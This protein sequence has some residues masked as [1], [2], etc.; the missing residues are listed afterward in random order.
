LT[1]RSA[2]KHVVSLGAE[3]R[4]DLERAARSNKRSLRERQRARILLA[5][6][7]GQ[8]DGAIA[9]AVRVHVNTV[10]N[11][12]RRFTAAGPKA[13][14]R[15]AEQANRKARR[16]DGRA[17]AHLVALVCGAPPQGRNRWSLHLLAGRLVQAGYVDAVSHETV[18]QTLKKMR[19]NPG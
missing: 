8:S 9:Q 10:A 16:L 17:E 7:A 11:V 15:R 1:L 12:R 4:A 13:S 5:A 19:S 3:A 14:V 2:K 6:A 18:R